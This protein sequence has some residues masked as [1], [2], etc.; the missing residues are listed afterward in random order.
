ME[1][2]ITLVVTIVIETGVALLF[3]LNPPFRPYRKR[4]QVDVPLTNL[5]THPIATLAILYWGLPFMEVELVVVVVELL[6]YRIVTR[7]PWGYAVSLSF[8][9]NGITASI[10]WIMAQALA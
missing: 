7:L 8:V 2:L 1:A 3:C 4:L 10:G 5:M 9:A 6:A